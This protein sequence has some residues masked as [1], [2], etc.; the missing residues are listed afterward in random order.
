MVISSDKAVRNYAKTRS[1]EYHGMLWIFDYLIDVNLISKEDAINKIQK[2]ISDNVFYK[3]NM[4][5]VSEITKRI[6]KWI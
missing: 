6:D 3:N 5:L 4:E 2:L 1:I